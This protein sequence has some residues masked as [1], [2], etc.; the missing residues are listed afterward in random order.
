MDKATA[1]ARLARQRELLRS[2]S[3]RE[4]SDPAFKKWERDT[5]LAI[6]HVF[7]LDTRHMKEFYDVRWLPRVHRQEPRST[8]RLE[9]FA[10][11]R[12]AAEAL[13]QSMIDEVRDYWPDAGNAAEAGEERKQ[14]AVPT[15]N[16]FLVHGRND[17]YRETVARFLEKL[18]LK[19]IILHEQPNKNRTII[20]KFEDYSNVSFAVI[21][22]TADDRGGLADAPYEAQKKRARQNVVL[23]LG[24]FLGKLG[25]GK[26]CP[27]YESGVELPSDYDGVVWVPLGE[28]DGWRLALAREIKAAGIAIDMN[29]VV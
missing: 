4:S 18:K 26:V 22:L 21:L 6:E 7:G 12:Q 3:A 10:R 8:E 29:N 25:R 1:I 20:E 5:Q 23:E 16:V 24:F 15:R 9:A 2:L 17:K 19:A 27:L 14:A 11:G 13:L 28:G